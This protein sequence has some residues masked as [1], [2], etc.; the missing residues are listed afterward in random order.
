MLLYQFFNE[1]SKYY[2]LPFLEKGYIIKICIIAFTNNYIVT[3]IYIVTVYVSLRL[4]PI[5]IKN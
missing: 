1:Y 5:G 4:I 3:L 2:G